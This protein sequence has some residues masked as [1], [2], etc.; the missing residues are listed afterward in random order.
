MSKKKPSHA[1]PE[2]I[3]RLYDLRREAVMRESR[4]TITG[5]FPK[6]FEDVLA[7]TKAD[8]QHWTYYRVVFPVRSY[9]PS[10]R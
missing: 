3:L 7:I 2:L 6:S 1:D 8:D 5:W 10:V 9:Q 4:R